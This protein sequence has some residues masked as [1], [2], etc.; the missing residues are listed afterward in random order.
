MGQFRILPEDGSFYDSALSPL[1]ER[2]SELFS[3]YPYGYD[4]GGYE[5]TII[6]A[7]LGF[8]QAKGF[9]FLKEYYN[10]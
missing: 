8:P 7:C 4:W 9:Y 6:L 3:G 10:E 1:P 2:V 5:Q